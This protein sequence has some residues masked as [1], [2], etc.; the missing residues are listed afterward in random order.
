MAYV[1]VPKDLSKVKTKFIF[2]LTKRQVFCFGCGI[3][4]G[5]PLFF[6]VRGSI[7]TTLS[8]LLMII[9]MMPFFLLALYEKNGEPLE[10]AVCDFVGAM[11]DRF[12]ILTY[13]ELFVPKSWEMI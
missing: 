3:L 8:A 4:V 12:A 2:N 9:V 1:T 13:N 10:I 6:L 7:P 5:L 11:T